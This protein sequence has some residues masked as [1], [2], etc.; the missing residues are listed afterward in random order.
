MGEA[1]EFTFE[2]GGIVG[3]AEAVVVG[4]FLKGVET[5]F[6]AV[7]VPQAAFDMDVFILSISRKVFIFNQRAT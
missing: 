5:H 3:E 4:G 1:D 6:I 2:D 7:S